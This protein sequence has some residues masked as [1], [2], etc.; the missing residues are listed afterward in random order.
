MP[1]RNQLVLA[2]TVASAVVA[3]GAAVATRRGRERNEVPDPEADF[4][5]YPSAVDRER[6][7]RTEDGLALHVEEVGAL[8]APVTVVFCHGW[9]NT[10]RAW[11]Y[12]RRDL[13]GPQV[14]LVF[15]DQRG[16]GRSG[17]PAPRHTDMEILGRD[18][19]RVID[20]TRAPGPVVLVGHS[21][22]AMSIMALIAEQPE[23]VASGGPVAG[24]ALL[25]TSAGNLARIT[26]GL[27][28][29]LA[30]T[31]GVLLPRAYR[32]LE[33]V[34]DRV[35]S[36]RRASTF[37]AMLARRI[38]YGQD[39][40]PSMVALMQDMF[41]QAPLAT[42]AGFGSALLFYDKLTALP[43]L[44]HT[45]TLILVGELDILTP[46]EHSEVL[47]SALPSAEFV[48][49]PGCGHMVM[50]ERHEETSAHLRS[51]LTRVSA[52]ASPVA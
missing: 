5:G 12:Q 34:G 37:G 27:P 6:V 31:S 32:A 3:G 11:V 38:G 10:Q 24:A 7:V 35:D 39:V 28:P 16:H 1:R 42:I 20:A 50:L 33:R 21:M 47:A 46:V 2:A 14:R 19:A 49:V 45:P 17:R 26:L 48:V 4:L 23:L 40:P 30:R 22:G 36:R 43:A 8:D 51:L 29:A 13:A 52:A 41:G 15:Y 18:L 25:S 44:A 9:T